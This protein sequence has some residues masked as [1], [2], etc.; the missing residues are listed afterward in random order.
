MADDNF[1]RNTDGLII[2]V[3]EKNNFYRVAGYQ[4]IFLM[5][6]TGSGKGV[7]FVLPNLLSS[8]ES[9][10]VHDI[11][12]ENYVIT[13]GWRASQGQAI[14]MFEPLNPEGKTHC[15]NPLDFISKNSD[16]M[17]NDIQKIAHI[18]LPDHC[19][20]CHAEIRNLF[21]A[22]VLYIMASLE[23]TKSFG[24]IYRILMGNVSEELT[25]A[26]KL[27]ISNAGL[28]LINNFLNKEKDERTHITSSLASHI[29]LWGNP[30]ID[31]ATSKSDFNPADFRKEKAT[32]YVGLH[33]ADI[34]RLR[35]LMQFFYQHIA[36]SFCASSNSEKDTHGVLFI[37][38]EFPTLGK[39]DIFTDSIPYFRG[40]KVRLLMIAQ[41]LNDV[42]ASYC[43]K[44]A[45][46]LLSNSTFKV[47][48]T[49][50]NIDTANFVSNLAIDR[51]KKE[52]SI[53][54]QTV[55][56]I[57]LDEQIIITDNEQPIISKKLRYHDFPEFK[58]RVIEP[59][60][61]KF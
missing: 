17:F 2:G 27:K 11:K 5:A 10:I 39:M 38:D 7:S 29:E 56:S 35:P 41:N 8:Q 4:H 40:Y 49:A 1:L 30:L 19:H 43:E 46:S 60:K 18:L 42:K 20:S 44:G 24:E 28:D 58:D 37:L 48:F 59:A 21:I 23:K 57:G 26:L 45:N 36:Q 31:Y 9:V 52:V 55:M 13:S 12:M 34:K 6:P 33:P 22:I 51:V 53:S 14:Y 50:N 15:Y 32:L 16:Q 54:W 47:A 3:D 25:A 61:L